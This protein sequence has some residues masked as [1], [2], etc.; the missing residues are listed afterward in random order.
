M[1]EFA[2]SSE[3]SLTASEIPPIPWDALDSAEHRS[4]LL[5]D[6]E[7]FSQFKSLDPCRMSTTEMYDILNL[8]TNAQEK[9]HYLLK[10]NV[11]NK[12][13]KDLVSSYAVDPDDIVEVA[14]P[15]PT[16][17]KS[18][19]KKII[20]D[21]DSDSKSD[22]SVGSVP[23][24]SPPGLT[25]NLPVNEVNGTFSPVRVVATPTSS[26]EQVEHGFLPEHLIASALHA[27]AAHNSSIESPMASNTTPLNLPSRQ[28]RPR[29]EAEQLEC[30]PN[31]P[32]SSDRAKKRVRLA[33]QPNDSD[34]SLSP[35]PP[36]VASTN[37]TLK[38]K[39]KETAPSSRGGKRGRKLKAGASRPKLSARADSNEKREKKIP[40]AKSLASKPPPP[41]PRQASKR[42]VTSP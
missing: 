28:K 19:A 25:T 9:E 29:I 15:P 4:T 7:P 32:A 30:S 11:N 37:T 8:I 17:K 35:G 33:E 3:E 6:S 36:T 27:V 1:T 12:I 5:M 39:T 40:A 26:T 13:V 18:R 23:D 10:F 22:S 42:Y 21:A 2:L 34:L 14:D 41:P 38:T 20:L 16:T 24:F 31:K